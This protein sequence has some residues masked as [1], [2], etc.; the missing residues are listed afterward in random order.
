MLPKLIKAHSELFLFIIL[1]F[2]AFISY[3]NSFA[4]EFQF[5][6]LIEM[7][8]AR[9]LNADF[10]LL[11]IMYDYPTRWVVYTT[12]AFNMLISGMDTYSYHALNWVI[13]LCAAFFIVYVVR[14]TFETPGMKN[15]PLRKYRTEIAFFTALLFVVH[16]L[17]ISAVT[18]V[19]QR[20]TSFMALSY[21]AALYF[22]VK[23]SIVSLPFK[24]RIFYSLCCFFA[25]LGF[26]S[27]EIF[28]TFPLALLVYDFYFLRDMSVCNWFKK[29]IILFGVAGILLVI[30]VL[31]VFLSYGIENVL[32]TRFYDTGQ[33]VSSRIYAVT[34]LK[35]IAHYIVLFFVPL[36]L[37]ADRFVE[38]TDNIFNPLIMSSLCMI[39]A[40]LFVAF[41]AY[42]SNK[43]LSFGIFWFF[44]TLLVDS[45]I[46]PTL[47]LMNEYRVYL[48]FL[49]LML[50]FLS[51]CYTICPEKRIIF[52]RF[53]LV[54][55]ACVFSIV[56]FQRNEIWQNQYSFWTDVIQKS[57]QKARA[58]NARA[59][60]YASIGAFESAQ[61]DLEQALSI[62]PGFASALY[63]LGVILV[64]KGEIEK[65]IHYYE[66][67]LKCEYIE[68]PF[69]KIGSML[70][71]AYL[72]LKKYSEAIQWCTY[73]IENKADSM[74]ESDQRV[75]EAYKNRAVAYAA[76]EEYERA[77]NDCT[78]LLNDNTFLI[79]SSMRSR[80][81]HYL[82]NIRGIFFNKLG[83]YDVALTNF[84]EA[85]TIIPN[86]S[87]VLFN[88]AFSL[89]M[90]N[91]YEEALL[92]L[93]RAIELDPSFAEAY[94]ERSSIYSLL[95]MDDSAR[96][97]LQSAIT[98]GYLIPANE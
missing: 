11:K 9:A 88:G 41:R 48:P 4:C 77:I 10:N 98:N 52:L 55:S 20:L 89:K 5:D 45:S 40:L 54:L 50:A 44:I 81:R 93:N 36:G 60:Y 73:V 31:F 67:A 13:H 19:V 23:G 94:S 27:K 72:E 12:F 22:Y 63:N 83:Y 6:T 42:R 86:D 26:F 85:L 18:Y 92:F 56:T 14:I 21:F 71:L 74:F 37:N 15:S 24:R 17:N 57:P 68:I 82:L 53:I 58:Y 51:W 46:F 30:A 28:Y 33:F 96:L 34:Q 97:D 91:R 39:L 38:A 84:N 78:F 32:V 95:H 43:L 16:P 76:I 66:E 25:F 69:S 1:I 70:V 49:G 87:G 47:N 65:G 64:K 90:L 59:N 7:I 80:E 75:W 29:R 3:W 79:P 2:F 35:V 62:R 8:N 61:A